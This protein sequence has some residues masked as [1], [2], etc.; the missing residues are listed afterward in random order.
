MKRDERTVAPATETG[1][2]NALTRRYEALRGQ[3]P[4]R[5]GDPVENIVLGLVQN[6]GLFVMQLAQSYL[7]KRCHPESLDERAAD[8][9]AEIVT[10]SALHKPGWFC[11]G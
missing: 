1:G 10:E 9:G 8:K 4:R 11:R 5:G 2:E 3:R 6:S 7:E